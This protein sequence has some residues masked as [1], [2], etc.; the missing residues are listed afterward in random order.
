MKKSNVNPFLKKKN[1]QKPKYFEIKKKTNKTKLL[2]LK[3]CEDKIE[4]VI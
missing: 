3:R 1:I 2:K 4:D